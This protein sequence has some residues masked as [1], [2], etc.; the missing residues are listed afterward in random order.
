MAFGDLLRYAFLF[1]AAGTFRALTTG[2]TTDGLLVGILERNAPDEI[3][4]VPGKERRSVTVHVYLNEAAKS[5]RAEGRPSV[6]YV[7]M[8]GTTPFQ[9]GPI[10]LLAYRR[11]VDTV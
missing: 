3:I 5:A 8:H 10:Y 4:S 1:S 11:R 9:A 2:I 6:T 7:N